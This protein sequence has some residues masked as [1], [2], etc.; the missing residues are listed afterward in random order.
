MRNAWRRGLGPRAVSRLQSRALIR[1]LLVFALEPASP[2]R[3]T[4]LRQ[5]VWWEL[6]HLARWGLTV[7]AIEREFREL[8]CAIRETFQVVG[9]PEVRAERYASAVER[10]LAE[11]FDWV[12]L[13][14]RPD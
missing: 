3:D 10:K 9:V 13:F 14:D 11:L 6:A 5:V 4:V 8:A 7:G 1:A 2:V 12:D